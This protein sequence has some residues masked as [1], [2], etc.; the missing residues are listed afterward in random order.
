MSNVNIR[1]PYLTVSYIPITPVQFHVS[2]IAFHLVKPL[3]VQ[4]SRANQLILPQT[5]VL[6]LN[7]TKSYKKKKTQSFFIY[8]LLIRS[9]F[10]IRF[11]IR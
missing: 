8:R 1:R 10:I 9:S 5:I 2:N 6:E 11:I 4:F 7:K 3:D